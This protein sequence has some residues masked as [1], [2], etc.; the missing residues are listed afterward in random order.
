MPDGQSAMPDVVAL[1]AVGSPLNEYFLMDGHCAPDVSAE[2]ETRAAHDHSTVARRNS[3][4]GAIGAV[5]NQQR[6]RRAVLAPE[7]LA[8]LRVVR[9]MFFL[10]IDL[11]A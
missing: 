5:V 9:A 1:A 10:A 8:R 6:L 3:L 4:V 11:C 7:R 2:A